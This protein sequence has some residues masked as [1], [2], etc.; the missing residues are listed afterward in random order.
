MLYRKCHIEISYRK[1][2]IKMSYGKY[3]IENTVYR[4]QRSSICMQMKD[5]YLRNEQPVFFC[6]WRLIRFPFFAYFLKNIK[7]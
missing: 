1:Y 2:Y 7:Y 3:W 5:R 4:T 6:R